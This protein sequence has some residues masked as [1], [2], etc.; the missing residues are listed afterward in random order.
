M[1]RFK[2]TE[3]GNVPFTPEEEQEWDA[4]ELAWNAGSRDR[5]A[6]EIKTE[7]N[8]KLYLSDWRVIKSL[9]SNQ[10]QDF[11]WVAYRQALRD[12][13]EQAGFPENVVW[14]VEP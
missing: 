1:S 2:A 11:A 8:K 3:D 7:R 6:A 10:L 13:T 14:P 9:E 4:R 5:L 12:M